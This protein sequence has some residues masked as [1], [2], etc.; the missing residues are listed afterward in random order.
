MIFATFH[1]T[2]TVP[3]YCATNGKAISENFVATNI[4]YTGTL[5]IDS[6]GKPSLCLA[7]FFE[8]GSGAIAGMVVDP[9]GNFYIANRTGKEILSYSPS[10]WTTPRWTTGVLNDSP[11][12]LLYVPASS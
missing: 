3:A 2:T 9:S 12:F 7:P 11:E 10:D 8:L 4:K 5:E 1:S 6:S